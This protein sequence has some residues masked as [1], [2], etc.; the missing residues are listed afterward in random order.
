M[1]ACNV[2]AVSVVSRGMMN[3]RVAICR[4]G[5][6]F[7]YLGVSVGVVPSNQPP[8]T[9]IDEF[10]KD[11]TYVTGQELAFSYLRDNCGS[12]RNVDKLVRVRVSLGDLGI[13]QT[14]MSSY[15]NVWR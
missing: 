7:V 2:G 12:T 15:Q 14:P 10:R 13:P 9:A 8:Q 4:M 3:V 11:V 1:H 5:K 6:I